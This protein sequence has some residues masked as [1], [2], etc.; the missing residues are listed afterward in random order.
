MGE[1]E[2]QAH[3]DATVIV[4]VVHGTY[5]DYVA[6][7]VTHLRAT[8]CRAAIHVIVL[9][10]T[11]PCFDDQALTVECIGHANPQWGE[12]DYV[13]LHRIRELCNVGRTCLQV[14]IDCYFHIDPTTYAALPYPF[15]ISRGLGFPEVAVKVWGFSLCTGFYIAKPT[16]LPLDRR[17]LDQEDLNLYLLQAGVIWRHAVS[18]LVTDAFVVSTDERIAVLPDRAITRD[19]RFDSFGGI[20]NR[21]VLGLHLEAPR[22]VS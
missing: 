10:A 1:R 16:A 7:W 4:T 3:D 14:D 18:P 21:S 9:D 20:H 11:E 6:G 2:V 8:G 17:G 13:R 5:H 19:P 15:V 12:G 22:T